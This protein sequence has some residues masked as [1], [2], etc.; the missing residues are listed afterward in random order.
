MKSNIF[1]KCKACGA[2]VPIEQLECP[3]CAQQSAGAQ[4]S[5]PTHAPEL[6]RD[7][8]SWV[9]GIS[10]P[11]ALLGIVA[12]FLP[13]VQVSCGP[14]R[15]RFSGYELATGRWEQKL[16]PAGIEDFWKRTEQQIDRQLGVP[17]RSKQQRKYPTARQAEREHTTNQS[18]LL[19]LVPGACAA[20]L[21]LALF[22]L[23]RV[24]TVLVSLVGAA[25]LAYF[26]ISFE[27]Q[28]SDP[29][30]TGGILEHSWLLGYWTS[31]LGLGAPF[32]AALMRP[33]RL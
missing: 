24:P 19:W 8:P 29:R 4:P 2:D 23:P 5:K 6:D 32:V 31:W 20:L 14:I 10:I 27:Q 17:P 28:A 13:W 12:F 21:L 7:T 9:R 33:R 16:E 11:S 25:Y 15:L 26:G 18:P 3:N 1:W 30:N 22:G